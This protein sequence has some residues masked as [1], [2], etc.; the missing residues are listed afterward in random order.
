MNETVIMKNTLNF[1]SIRFINPT[2]LVY[3][4]KEDHEP[5]TCMT[6]KMNFTFHVRK[7][8]CVDICNELKECD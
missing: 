6:E 7:V 3:G 8:G 4:S 5:E 2:S 1:V